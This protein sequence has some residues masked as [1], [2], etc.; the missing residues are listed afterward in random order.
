MFCITIHKLLESIYDSSNDIIII[1][2]GIFDKCFFGFKFY[3]EELCSY[4]YFL[5]YLTLAKSSQHLIPNLCIHFTSSPEESIRRR[6]GEGRLVTTKWLN[7]YN[8]IFDKFLSKHIVDFGN[9]SFFSLDTT[10]LSKSEV[11][12]IVSDKIASS[13]IE[14]KNNH[15]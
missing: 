8:H 3:S 14:H 6:G 7:N 4:D 11:A 15:E 13:Y 5:L 2:R 1:D 10:C 12:Q 9:M